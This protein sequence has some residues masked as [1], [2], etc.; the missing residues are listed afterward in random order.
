[1]TV[2]YYYLTL[3]EERAVVLPISTDRN[4]HGNYEARSFYIANKRTI[5]R[6][7]G[8]GQIVTVKK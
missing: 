5:E 6:R 8:N 4:I 1:M 7:L 2:A 3:D